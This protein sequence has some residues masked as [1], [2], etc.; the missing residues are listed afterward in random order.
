MS[1]ALFA[2]GA[3]P[4]RGFLWRR[5]MRGAVL[6][7]RPGEAEVATRRWVQMYQDSQRDG[8]TLFVIGPAGDG[9]TRR[10]VQAMFRRGWSVDI[11][12][13]ADAALASVSERP[14]RWG[15]LVVIACGGGDGEVWDELRAALPDHPAMRLHVAPAGT[16]ARVDLFNAGRFPRGLRPE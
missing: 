12:D 2:G 14:E 4:R 8:A 6:A 15:L 10:L 3:G 13:D 7:A 5:A 9:A 1:S 11:C 16:V